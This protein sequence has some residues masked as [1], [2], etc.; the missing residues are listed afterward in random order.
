MIATGGGAFMDEETRALIL[1]RCLA[2]W[3][4]ADVDTLAARVARRSHRPL[5]A[6]KDPRR[7]LGELAAVRNPVYAEAHLRVL[8]DS[9]PHDRTV[10]RILEALAER[11]R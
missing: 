2:V 5:L 4:D 6:G 1:R 3:L 7:L 11:A 9:G 8:S 10:E